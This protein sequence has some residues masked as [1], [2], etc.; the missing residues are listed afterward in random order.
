MKKRFLPLLGAAALL[1]ALAAC[2]PYD[3]SDRVSQVRS[4]LFLAQTEAFSL[5]LACLEQEYP[6]ADDGIPCPMTRSVQIVLEPIEAPKGG[7][8]IYVGEGEAQWGGEASY[9]TTFGHYTLSAGVEEF[10]AESVALTVVYG[11]T[12]HTLAATSVRTDETLS[13]AEALARGVEAER[14]TLESMQREDA[15]CGELCVRLIH[16]D[17]N[18]YY[19]AVTD[20]TRRVAL[21]LDAETGE[22][23]ARREDT[24][25]S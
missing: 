18:Y 2:A 3:Y 17:K 23:L 10:P 11:D 14:E 20:G 15:F 5:T 16:R 21:L 25:R 8:E 13:P 7:V 1:P 12:T 6:Y 22:V 24:M 9:S 19:F 4:D